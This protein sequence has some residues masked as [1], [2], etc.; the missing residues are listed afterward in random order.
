MVSDHVSV[1]FL[2]RVGVVL[3]RG[4]DIV[5]VHA[6]VL[7]MLQV[8]VKRALVGRHVGMQLTHINLV[9]SWCLFV[10]FVLV[11]LVVVVP[12]HVTFI[13]LVIAG[14]A[15]PTG[16]CLYEAKTNSKNDVEAG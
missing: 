13:V 12:S 7:L 11:V 16:A 14:I 10:E 2:R 3:L 6:G 1:S 8:L 5:V 9:S 4:V 15:E